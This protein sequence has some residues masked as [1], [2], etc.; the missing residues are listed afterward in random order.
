MADSA[1][2]EQWAEANTVFRDA[3]EDDAISHW[4]K[5][6]MT[7]SFYA[8]VHWAECLLRTR[9]LRSRSHEER[10]R[11]LRADPT[12]AD[13]ADSYDQ[14]KQ[15]STDERYEC[16]IHS[17]NQRALARASLNLLQQEV[18]RLR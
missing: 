18:I 6:F 12:L 17:A 8:A 4:E 1:A 16:L 14:L 2:H 11:H 10:Q 3:I 15:W 9:S 13:I 5:W 7:A